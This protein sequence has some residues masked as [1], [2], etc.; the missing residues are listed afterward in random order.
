MFGHKYLEFR[1]K[2]FHMN[3]SVGDELKSK[4]IF[5]FKIMINKNI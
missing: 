4:Y 1:I 2:M 5:N 3:N